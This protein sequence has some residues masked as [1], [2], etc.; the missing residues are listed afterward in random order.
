MYP[1][2]QVY[3]IITEKGSSERTLSLS[4]SLS[5]SQWEAKVA[6]AQSLRAASDFTLAF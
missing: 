4:L 3:L 1:I 2:M 5:L 6:L